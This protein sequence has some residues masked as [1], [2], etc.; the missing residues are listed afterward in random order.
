MEI[1]V[2]EP[3]EKELREL[4]ARDWPIWEKDPGAFD[5]SYDS[6]ETC[7]LLEGEAEIE[8]PDGKK[9]RIEKGDLVIFPKGLKCRW[10]VLK[11]V[12]KHYKFS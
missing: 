9:V 10:N 1:T 3:A 11:K 7:F 8:T 2:K 4:G 12:R 5:W 6:Q